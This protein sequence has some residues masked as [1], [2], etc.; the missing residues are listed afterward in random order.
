VPEWVKLV[1]KVAEYL[2]L[3]RTLSRY[4]AVAD[5]R[6]ATA[7]SF[8]LAMLLPAEVYRELSQAVSDPSEELNELTVLMSVRRHA[9]GSR[10]GVSADVIAHHA[11]YAGKM[12]DS[13]G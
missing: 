11:P 2:A 13:Q 4:S 5:F 3:V 8:E 7:L 12:P 9:L 10:G 6:R 1:E